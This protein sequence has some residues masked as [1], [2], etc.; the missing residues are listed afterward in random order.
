M[1]VT[2]MLVGDDKTNLFVL[3]DTIEK[4]RAQT[5]I[6]SFVNNKT[7]LNFL[8][9]I[10]NANNFQSV[11]VP[12]IILLDKN[13]TEKHELT[14]LKAFNKL[15]NLENKCISIYMLCDYKL[16]Q[17]MEKEE[18]CFKHITKPLSSKHIDKIITNYKPFLVQYDYMESDINMDIN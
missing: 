7:A 5:S 6:K 4:S 2:I 1:K 10:N 8:K 3:R 15:K 13:T 14:F 16:V 12:N 11:K 17:G 18:F 9:Q